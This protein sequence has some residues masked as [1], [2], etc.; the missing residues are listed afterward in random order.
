MFLEAGIQ[1]IS[2]T[3]KFFENLDKIMKN[4]L[5]KS[6]FLVNLQARNLDN[7]FLHTFFFKT[8]NLKGHFPS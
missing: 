2:K 1:E 4:Y 6:S 8:P 5:Q 3:T 7:K